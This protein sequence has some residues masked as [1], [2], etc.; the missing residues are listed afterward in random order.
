MRVGSG[1]SGTLTILNDD[2]HNLKFKMLTI[3]FNPTWDHLFHRWLWPYVGQVIVILYESYNIVILLRCRKHQFRFCHFQVLSMT[4][5]Q[6]QGHLK[7][8]VPQSSATFYLWSRF[9][10]STLIYM[11]DI[12]VDKIAFFKNL[13]SPCGFDTVNFICIMMKALPF[14]VYNPSFTN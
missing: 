12:R 2:M 13:I 10:Q 9:H 7:L 1:S 3:F 4:L 11:W 6:S 8:H 14:V 5:T